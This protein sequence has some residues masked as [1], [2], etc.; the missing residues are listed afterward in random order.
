MEIKNRSRHVATTELIDV[1]IDE[2]RRAEFFSLNCERNCERVSAY[3]KAISTWVE[4][5]ISV[6][7]Y[8]SYT[9]ARHLRRE[10]SR[11]LRLFETKGSLLAPSLS[12]FMRLFVARESKQDWRTLNAPLIASI[13]FIP[14]TARDREATGLMQFSWVGCNDAR[15]KRATSTNVIRTRVFRPKSNA[16][17]IW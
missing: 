10:V 2:M 8:S 9:P 4:E 1:T 6:S 12:R 7:R 3:T 15:G 16:S 11:L 17:A 5:I 13:W 14:G